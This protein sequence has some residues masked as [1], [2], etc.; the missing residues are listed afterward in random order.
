MMCCGHRAGLQALFLY[1]A[2]SQSELYF[3]LEVV[4][5]HSLTTTSRQIS[6]KVGRYLLPG[7]TSLLIHY[8]NGSYNYSPD[9]FIPLPPIELVIINWITR[10]LTAAAPEDTMH[11]I[12]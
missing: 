9:Q 4:D 3:Y 12:P 2:D 11:L 7:T 1:K 8:A 10:R 6:G 5:R